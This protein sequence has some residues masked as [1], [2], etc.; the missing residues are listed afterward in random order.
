MAKSPHRGFIRYKSYSFISKDPI[1]D[2]FRTLREDSGLSYAEING[3]GGPPAGTMRN[4][5]F[6]DVKRPQFAT[7]WAAAR[8]C[9]ATGI[10][11]DSHGHPRFIKK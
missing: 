1:I 10:V 11:T 2:A 4:W 6:G 7:V 9:G 5:E 8:A 3:D